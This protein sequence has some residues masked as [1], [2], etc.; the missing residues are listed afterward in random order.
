MLQSFQLGITELQQL[1]VVGAKVEVKRDAGDAQAHQEDQVD[2]R[3]EE[4]RGE[5]YTSNGYGVRE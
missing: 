1:L 4:Q 3:T 2:V 5:T